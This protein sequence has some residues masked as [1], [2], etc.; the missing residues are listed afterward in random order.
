MFPSISQ[1]PHGRST[2]TPRASQPA[3]SLIWKGSQAPSKEKPLPLSRKHCK[4]CVRISPLGPVTTA[5]PAL[6][7]QLTYPTPW[8]PGP[9]AP[10]SPT[11]PS[12]LSLPAAQG[13]VLLRALSSSLP[14]N[15]IHIP[16][17]EELSQP[18][19]LLQGALHQSPSPA[20]PGPVFP[21]TRPSPQGQHGQSMTPKKV[22]WP[23]PQLSSSLVSSAEASSAPP[24]PAETGGDACGGAALGGQ[25]VTACGVG[26]GPAV[27]L[28]RA[29]VPSLTGPWNLSIHRCLLGKVCSGPKWSQG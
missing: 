27:S 1:T 17:L 11:S 4:T 12:C 18:R 28:P 29:T 7:G 16:G 19:G 20:P 24:S 6:Q 3:G 13:L 22:M 10:A 25:W 21:S 9:V 8:P 26:E 2:R 15:S 23:R 14:W 5:S